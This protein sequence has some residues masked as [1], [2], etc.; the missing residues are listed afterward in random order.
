MGTD[1][2]ASI[3]LNTTK[4]VTARA[5]ANE[6]TLSYDDNLFTSTVGTQDGLTVT[7]DYANQYLTLNGTWTGKSIIHRT[8]ASGMTFAANDQYKIT[9]TPISGSFTDSNNNQPRFVMDL[10]TNGERFS[11]RTTAPL[12]YTTLIS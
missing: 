10:V 7:Y 8:L 9:I 6:Y 12:S 5:K 2:G 11:A 4:C 3:S 1:V